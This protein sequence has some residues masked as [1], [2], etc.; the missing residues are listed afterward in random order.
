MNKEDIEFGGGGVPELILD[1]INSHYKHQKRSEMND[2]E[3]W[4]RQQLDEIL[5]EPSINDGVP[6]LE[7]L[8]KDPKLIFLRELIKEI[9]QWE[10]KTGIPKPIASQICAMLETQLIRM[11]ENISYYRKYLECLLPKFEAFNERIGPDQDTPLHYAIKQHNR[12]FIEW[13]LTHDSVDPNIRNA[14][15][16]TPLFLLCEDFRAGID[17]RDCILLLLD[18]GAN[19]NIYSGCPSLAFELLM[20]DQ[21]EENLKFLEECTRRH[22]YGAIAIG[23]TNEELKKRCVGFYQE[24]HVEVNVTVELLEVFLGFKEHDRFIKELAV[25][26]VNEVNV[27]NL[28]KV[29]L[30]TAVELGLEECVRKIVQIGRSQIFQFNNGGMVYSFE[31][32]GL[33]K[34]ACIRGNANILKLL[35]DSISDP[36]LVNEDPLLVDTL[37][38][39]QGD[40][41]DSMLKCAEILIK[42]GKVSYTLKDSLGNTAL[43]M[44]A[45]Y[46]FKETAVRLL[47]LKNNFLGVRNRDNLTPLDYAG[48]EFWKYCFDMCMRRVQFASNPNDDEIWFNYNC[49][50]P[51]DFEDSFAS[52]CC[53][54]SKCWPLFQEAS[55]T[56]VIGTPKQLIMTEMDPLKVISNSKQLQSLLLHPFIQTFIQIKWKGMNK[57]CYLNLIVTLLTFCSYSWYSWNACNVSQSLLIPTSLTLVGITYMI[58]RELLQIDI[59]RFKYVTSLENL[60]DILTIIGTFLSL[61]TGCNPILSS[62]IVIAFVR[63]LT[64]LIGSL[65]FKIA[66]YMH[67]F[68]TITYNFLL[69][70]L[71][72]IPWLS[73]FTYCFYLSH[74]VRSKNITSPTEANNDSFNTFGT[75]TDAALK[76]LVMTTGEFDASNLDLNDGKMILLVLFIFFVPF[77]FLNLINGLAVSDITEIR[78]E[79]ELIG[80]RKK[81]MVLYRNGRGSRNAFSFVKLFSP[82]SFLSK[83][84]CEIKVKPKEIRKIMVLPKNQTKTSKNQQYGSIPS[85]WEVLP[86]F[87]KCCRS[88]KAVSNGVFLNCRIKIPLYCTLD[89]H[90]LD[91]VLKIVDLGN[92]DS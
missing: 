76:T 50:V 89:K 19:F 45:K 31:L 53:S 23:K 54:L 84:H 16:K 80:I 11:L 78:K 22:R 90:L 46:G 63:Q 32:N 29:L 10:S 43:H 13:L 6:K 83:H 51:H 17:V 26:K 67:M 73:A 39:A 5:N 44:A 2:L 35:L 57:W 28:I 40:K 33:L 82:G 9:Q 27:R 74:S 62:L 49:F 25:L 77:V 7:I 92:A 85:N 56:N 20:D 65:P 88:Q 68:N 4:L 61:A 47:Q 79:A 70:F 21:S 38:K 8:V 91:E 64:I 30:H 66:T 59:L 55:V 14:Q 12:E 52:T 18:K 60:L 72:F 41:R 58:I 3:K 34:K 69:S 71:L 48:C 87:P 81:V 1:E 86:I 42:S 75:F 37:S 36:S 24:P 15:S